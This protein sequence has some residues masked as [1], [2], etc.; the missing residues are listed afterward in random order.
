MWIRRWTG[1]LLFLVA[2][3]V[4]TYP[5]DDT[6]EDQEPIE[7]GSIEVTATS[8]ASS[9]IDSLPGF[10][11]EAIKKALKDKGWDGSCESALDII[12]DAVGKKP[13]AP[14]SPMEL[15]GLFENYI[16]SLFRGAVKK[17]FEEAEKA[18]KKVSYAD[19]KKFLEDEFGLECDE[20]EPDPPD[21]DPEPE[22]GSFPPRGTRPLLEGD[23][24][25]S[26][27]PPV[28]LARYTARAKSGNAVRSREW[29]CTR[30]ETPD[31]LPGER[32]FDGAEV[33]Y[34]CARINTGSSTGSTVSHSNNFEASLITECFCGAW[35]VTFFSHELYANGSEAGVLYE[36]TRTFDQGKCTVTGPKTLSGQS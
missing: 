35:K 16:P 32:A 34:I 19:L 3:C 1:V 24:D 6:S 2:S 31:G 28:R 21:E 5:G 29:Y 17:K 23:E 30:E 20:P 25:T 15:F 18:G 13:P 12:Y 27:P 7:L 26:C 4:V 9:S 11:K 10:V 22:A 33:G 36:Y 8:G 14:L